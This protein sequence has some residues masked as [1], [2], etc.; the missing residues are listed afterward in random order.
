MYAGVAVATDGQKI[1]LG[2][3]STLGSRANVMKLQMPMAAASRLK[4][5]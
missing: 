5:L 1:R 3:V 4:N 2:I